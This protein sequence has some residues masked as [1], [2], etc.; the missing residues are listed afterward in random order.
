MNFCLSVTKARLLL[1]DKLLVPKH[2]NFVLVVFL[3]K[4]YLLVD[5]SRTNLLRPTR[6]IKLSIHWESWRI[7]KYCWLYAHMY[8]W[9]SPQHFRLE[10]TRKSLHLEINSTA[11][12]LNL[13]GQ[14]VIFPVQQQ[15]SERRMMSLSSMMMD[16]ASSAHIVKSMVMLTHWCPQ[17]EFGVAYHTKYPLFVPQKNNIYFSLFGI[18]ENQEFWL[19]HHTIC[20][21]NVFQKFCGIVQGTGTLQAQHHGLDT[22]NQVSISLWK[23]IHAQEWCALDSQLGRYL[24]LCF[25]CNPVHISFA[26]VFPSVGQYVKLVSLTGYLVNTPAVDSGRVNGKTSFLLWLW[27]SHIIVVGME[28]F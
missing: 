5:K 25:Q 3:L 6:C 24:C 27:S 16:S 11:M 13:P 18:F 22:S 23:Q 28:K 19:V 4:L 14:R 10:S 26:Q 17:A 21:E 20:V 9:F 15:L 1:L 2:R 12:H 8:L 7:S